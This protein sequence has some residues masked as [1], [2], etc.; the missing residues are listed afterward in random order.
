[1]ILKDMF[2]RYRDHNVG[3]SAAALTYYLIF[4]FFPFLIFSSNLLG[5]LD[6]PPLPI[7]ELQRIIP[8][9]VLGIFNDYL[10]HVTQNQSTQLMLFGLV[11]S[12]YFPMRAVHSLMDYISLAY[13]EPS[14]VHP[15]KR[16]ILDL[17]F[18]IG[19]ITVII[20]AV[21]FVI[22]GPALLSWIG[23]ILPISLSL[24]NLWGVLRFVI[25]GGMMLF[26]LGALY[27]FAP[28]VKITVKSVIPGA[29]GSLVFWM[30]YSIGFSFYVEN[31][32]NYSG[33]Y[34]SIGAIIVLLIW[35]YFTSVTLIVGAEFN[36][37]LKANWGDRKKP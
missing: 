9:D 7:D 12:V 17:A 29:I 18:T 16:T 20:I 23:H 33:L 13:G 2:I 36:A 22:I 6:L 37:S 24:I 10:T 27:Y 14:E 8:Q 21:I 32:G 31:M 28:A 5:M 19:L 11:F 30:M 26:N 3:N 1:M 35:L 34:G 15:I 25:L 4:S